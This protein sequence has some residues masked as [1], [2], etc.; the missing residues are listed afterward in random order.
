MEI[1]ANFAFL[2][3]EFPYVAKAA[4]FAERHV[5][6]DPRGSCF[7]ARNA[8]EL[9]IKRIYRVDKTLNPPKNTNHL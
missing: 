5:Y 6:G 9:L 4:T 2:K 1:S 3:Q 7:H 8:L